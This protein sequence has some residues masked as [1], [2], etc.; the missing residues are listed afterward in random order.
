[1]TTIAFKQGI[2]AADSR[3]TAGGH[4]VSDS[5]NKIMK[6]NQEVSFLNGEHFVKYIACSGVIL[7][8]EAV[9]DYLVENKELSYVKD[10]EYSCFILTD[11]ECFALYFN[12][13]NNAYIDKCFDGE[14]IGSGAA[15]AVSA[16]K[17]GL[18]AVDAVKHACKLDVYSGGRVRS[19]K[20]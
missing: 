4:I 6:I 12:D 16:M 11:K 1:M 3:V 13:D 10:D 14:A 20:I 9:R 19:V 8:L 7:S 18:S 17:M 5:H 15:F 2:L